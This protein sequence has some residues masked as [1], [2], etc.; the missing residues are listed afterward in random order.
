MTIRTYQKEDYAACMEILKSN[1]PQFF[2]M[3][4]IPLFEEW[5][6]AQE[7]GLLAYAVSEKEYYYVLEDNDEIIGCAGYLLVKNTNEIYLSWGMVN[8]RF[9]KLGYGKK[10]L[11]Y[12]ID[13]IS[14]H[15]PDKKIVLA[16]TQNIAPFFEKYGF[17]TTNIKPKFYSESLDRYE[18]EK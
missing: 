3:E 2:A 1:T 10:L 16:T 4:E 17:K 11:K 9:Q 18:M 15:F 13:S 5:L 6:I 12:R 14:Q 8:R 7:K